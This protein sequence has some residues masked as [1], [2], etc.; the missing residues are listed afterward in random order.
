[1]IIKYVN[2]SDRK[3]Y[4]EEVNQNGSALIYLKERDRKIYLEAVKQ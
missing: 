2:N 3:I 1:M 4:L